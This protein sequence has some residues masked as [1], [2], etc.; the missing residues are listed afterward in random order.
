MLWGR[1]ARRQA[2]IV[3]NAN[4]AVFIL[5]VKNVAPKKDING[6]QCM[7]H[8]LFFGGETV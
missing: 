3:K 6:R 2:L 5:N 4:V 1:R 8:L 7:D